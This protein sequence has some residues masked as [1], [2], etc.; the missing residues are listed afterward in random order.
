M[1]GLPLF[2]ARDQDEIQYYKAE[3]ETLLRSALN[4]IQL[5][6]SGVYVQ[7][8]TLGSLEAFL[9]FLETH[10]IP[11]RFCRLVLF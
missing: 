2:V 3:M 1:A 10:R 7:T 4:S 9:K 6:D 11:V 5:Q 8:S